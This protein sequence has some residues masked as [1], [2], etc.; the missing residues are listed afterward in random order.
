MD[1]VSGSPDIANIVSEKYNTL[2][3]SVS[4]NKQDMTNL[5]DEVHSLCNMD[6]FHTGSV[7]SVADVTEAI[8]VLQT[9]KYDGFRGHTLIPLTI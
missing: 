5:C 3:N 7:I 8:S 6:S 4:Y 1:G 9:N 2:H